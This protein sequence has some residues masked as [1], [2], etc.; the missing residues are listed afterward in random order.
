MKKILIFL[1]VAT[2]LVS[3]HKDLE[4]EIYNT[5]SPTTFPKNKSDVSAAVTSMYSSIRGDGW[6]QTFSLVDHAYNAVS[7]M[8]TDIFNTRWGGQWIALKTFG[9]NEFTGETAW[10]YGN[11]Y[12]DISRAIL[13]IDRIKDVDM[14]QDLLNRY[15]GEIKAIQGWMAWL[16]Y[17]LYGPVGIPDLEVLKNPLEEVILERPSNESMVNYIETIMNEAIAVLPES[18]E[19]NDWGRVTKGTAMMVLLKLYMHEKNWGKAEETARDIIS[20]GQYQLQDDYNYVFSI[21]GQRNN[22]II[23]AAPSSHESGNPWHAHV[24]PPNM[25]SD[26]P[27]KE[28]WGGYRMRWAFYDTFEPQDERLNSVISEYVGTDGI[29]YKRGDANL[30]D[31]A[32]AIPLKYEIDPGAVTVFSEIDIVIFRYSDVLLSLSEAIANKNGAPN[33]ECMDL[34]NMVRNRAG[35]DN[36]DLVD[37]ASLGAF[38]DMILLERGHELFCEGGRRQDLIR[39][40]KYIE[41]GK[42]IPG[43]QAGDHKVLF[44]IPQW[45]INE[46]K[47]IIKQNDGY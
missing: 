27:N 42:T 7:D 11:R 28:Q 35:L 14:D 47:G 2:F 37:Y 8:S 32:G 5:I 19:S 39:H 1:A 45:A 26:K 3:C 4:P 21:D 36:L 40:G 9:W 46:G 38:N 43:N 20:L 24:M 17:D 16:I 29:E 25:D 33:Q 12:K 6:G 44:P 41:F 13:T 18:Y 30:E 22:E 23:H 15:I 31:D 10:I 34:I